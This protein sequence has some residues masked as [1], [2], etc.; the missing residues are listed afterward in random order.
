M[1]RSPSDE[2]STALLSLLDQQEQHFSAPDARPW[3]IAA[4]NPDQPPELPKH[5]TPAQLASWTVL[6]QVLLNL[7]ETI[8]RE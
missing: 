6:S 2:E 3:E 1:S 5:T 4:R 7:D 8:T